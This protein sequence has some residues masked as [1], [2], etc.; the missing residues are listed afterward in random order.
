MLDE[1]QVKAA[2]TEFT[3]NLPSIGS[4]QDKVVF[5]A[6]DG[7][8]E[9]ALKVM[10]WAIPDDEDLGDTSP[11]AT[12]ME[13]FDRE[14]LAMRTV[15]C[16]HVAT[17]T[18]GPEVRSI[19]GKNHLWFGEPLLNGGTLASVRAGGRLTEG[20]V[21]D[22][23]RA[24]FT[25]IAA[26]W[27]AGQLVHRDIKPRNIGYIDGRVVLTDFGAVLFTGLS[28]L[29]SPSIAGPGTQLY[30]SPEQFAPRRNTT[31]DFRSDL[32]QVG[33]VLHEAIT[34]VHPFHGRGSDYYAALTSYDPASLDGTDCPETLKTLVGRLLS[35]RPA[36]RFRSPELALQMLEDGL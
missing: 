15:S 31:L 19:G 22:L 28:P 3:V 8:D 30:A 24:L 9:F 25:A 6:E 33:I 35:E 16:P 18:H 34:G 14:M 32:F 21:I 20:A 29:T 2:F 26:M 17:I 7:P 10:S 23:A 5:R 36:E 12:T 4:G 13:R 27:G 11:T 1:G